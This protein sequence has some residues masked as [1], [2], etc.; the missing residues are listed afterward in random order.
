MDTSQIRFRWATMGTPDVY[1]NSDANSSSCGVTWA[2]SIWTS[3]TVSSHP[4]LN[5]C[6]IGFLTKL[7]TLNIKNDLNLKLYFFLSSFLSALQWMLWVFL[8]VCLLFGL[9]SGPTHGIW[10]FPGQGSDWSYSCS[11]MPQQ[12]Q[13][14]AMSA[15]DTT[16]HGNAGYLTHWA[17]SGIDPLS[18]GI[19]VGF[20]NHWA[21][22]GTP[23]FLSLV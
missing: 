21:T 18:W 2:A 12:C 19:L 7:T 8:F 13:I 20:V 15:N 23:W 14:Q 3:S 5:L 1:I 10:K 17:R 9:F 6:F 4:L 11:P 16:P 22:T